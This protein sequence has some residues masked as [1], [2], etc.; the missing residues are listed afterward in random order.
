PGN[1]QQTVKRTEDSFQ[2]CNDIVTCFQERARVER[3]YAQQLNEWSNKWKPVV[4]TSEYCTGQRSQVTG[5][6]G[7]KNICKENWDMS[8]IQL[9]L[10]VISVHIKKS[11]KQ[12]EGI[13]GFVPF[14][15]VSSEP[16]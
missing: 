7:L 6:K 12:T 10:A 9:A 16:H 15:S 2:A 5:V 3:L 1:Y 13:L 8:R 4:D 14:Y 11:S